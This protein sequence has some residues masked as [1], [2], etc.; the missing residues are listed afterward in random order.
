MRLLLSGVAALSFVAV[1]A[2]EMTEPPPGYDAQ[3][4]AAAAIPP[5]PQ[6]GAN[7]PNMPPMPRGPSTASSFPTPSMP[8]PATGGPSQMQKPTTAPAPKTGG[9]QTTGGP[10]QMPKPPT[11]PAPAT[12]A[13]HPSC[14]A[15]NIIIRTEAAGGVEINCGK[16]PMAPPASLKCT[17]PEQLTFLTRNGVS[18]FAC[19]K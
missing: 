6:Y 8:T 10:S 4:D 19:T 15:P 1:T 18:N 9:T 17:A 2:C 16:P 11:A 12:P 14:S 7:A 13:F 3:A 5:L